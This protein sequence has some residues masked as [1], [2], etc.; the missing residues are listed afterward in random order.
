M[1]QAA[2]AV[3]AAPNTR[4]GAAG[5]AAG[6]RQG[7]QRRADAR[8]RDGLPEADLARLERPGAQELLLLEQGLAERVTRL[9]AGTEAQLEAEAAELVAAVRRDPAR[10]PSAEAALT[11]LLADF[12]SFPAGALQGST[13]RRAGAWQWLKW[14]ACWP[15]A[16]WRHRRPPSR[17]RK[18]CRAPAAA[19]R[20]GDRG[21]GRA[22]AREDRGLA[23]A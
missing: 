4:H 20:G 15:A 16:I 13:R 19:L 14:K 7:P 18:T 5:P 11:E 9:Q 22:P 2:Q 6:G 23:T 21:A 12:A 10:A 1:T 3:L 17:G 8:A